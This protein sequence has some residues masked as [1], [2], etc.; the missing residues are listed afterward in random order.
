MIYEE[1]TISPLVGVMS[2][3]VGCPPS[4]VVQTE[5]TVCGPKGGRR[6]EEGERRK[7]EGGR[8]YKPDISMPSS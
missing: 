7:E 8:M 1:C 6:K 5:H 4:V 3:V 2:T